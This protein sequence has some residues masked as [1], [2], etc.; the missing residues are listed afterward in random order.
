MLKTIVDVGGLVVL[1]ASV[2]ALTWQ[3]KISND[4][5]GASVLSNAMASDRDVDRVMLQY[6]GLRAYFYDDKPCPS[7]GRERERVLVLTGM[8]ADVLEAGL[9]STRRVRASESYEDWRSYSHFVLAHSPT[10]RAFVRE[11]PD[12]WPCLAELS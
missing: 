9:M 10:M 12:W 7:R 5:A 1:A 11:H 3:T 8:Y 4:I 6:P 2:L